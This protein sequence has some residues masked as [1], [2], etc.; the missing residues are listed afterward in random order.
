[1]CCLCFAFNN[2]VLITSDFSTMKKSILF[3]L[4]ICLFCV[5][6]HNNAHIRTQKIL[7]QDETALSV[8]GTANIIGGWN[9]G[10]YNT[11]TSTNVFGLRSE[12]SYLK[13]TGK[14]DFGP[15][16]GIGADYA[17]GGGIILG[18][19]YRKYLNLDKARPIKAGGQIEIN[20]SPLGQTLHIRPTLTTATS[21]KKPDYYGV[22]GI[23]ASGNLED[24]VFWY[25]IDEN[26][27]TTEYYYN[28]YSKIDSI[29]SYNFY[30]QGLGITLGTQFAKFK[31]IEIQLQ[32]DFSLIQNSFKTAFSFPN[33]AQTNW[34][35]AQPVNYTGIYP[36][37]SASIGANFL[38][39]RTTKR[40]PLEPLPSPMHQESIIAQNVYDPETGEILKTDPVQY[41]PETG[42]ILKRGAVQYDPET[43][44]TLKRS[45]VQYDPEI[46]EL[47]KKSTIEYDS[48]IK[49]QFTDTTKKVDTELFFPEDD[50]IKRAIKEANSQHKSLLWGAFG[51]TALPAGIF[52]S[53]MG[54]V[55]MEVLNNDF[56]FAGF[57]G[58]GLFGLTVPTNLAKLSSNFANINYPH[59][60]MENNKK[61]LYKSTY[62]KEVKRLR[63]KS[64]TRGTVGSLGLCGLFLFSLILA[65]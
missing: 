59:S 6:C 5:G 46:D 55:T 60:S 51:A 21:N 38:K 56:A 39:P 33:N 11:L 30:S 43:G 14:S 23:L 24:R 1:M 35:T 22:H 65:V 26:Y 41:D 42:E 8:S 19:D 20:F 47:P 61:K 31:N 40:K 10:G 63:A 49:T 45:T 18:Y 64:T 9:P 36:L 16:L 29:V 12:A 54:V 3:F 37:F 15:Y 34:R 48:E 50:I 52:G 32:L 7:E 13:G 57:L 2:A 53:I 27:D 44:E 62:Q 28:T 25:E 58:G 4:L 17:G